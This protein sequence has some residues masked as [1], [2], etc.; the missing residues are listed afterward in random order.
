MFHSYLLKTMLWRV[1]V[2][3]NSHA[4]ISIV[5]NLFR[6]TIHIMVFEP[7]RYQTVTIFSIVWY[8][9]MSWDKE[10]PC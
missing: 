10:I 7:V 5:E 2:L 6:Y 9:I 1:H 8:A 3:I 4:L